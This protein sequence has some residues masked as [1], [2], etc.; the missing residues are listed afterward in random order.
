M[1]ILVL[2]LSAV[3]GLF[4]PGFSDWRFPDRRFRLSDI[5]TNG[6]V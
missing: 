1:R 5:S 3:D 4:V 6:G 2:K